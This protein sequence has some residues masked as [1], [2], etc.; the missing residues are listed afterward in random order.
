MLAFVTT[1]FRLLLNLTVMFLLVMFVVGM[2]RQLVAPRVSKSLAAA[3]GKSKGVGGYLLAL[4]GGMVTPFC[5]CSAVPAVVG[6]LGGGVAMGVVITFL[7]AAPVVHEGTFLLMWASMGPK[8]ALAFLITAAAL[9]MVLGVIFS[10]F[11]LDHLVN[12]VMIEP[13]RETALTNA[14]SLKTKVKVSLLQAWDLF[15]RVWPYLLV[16]V[17]IGAVMENFVPVETVQRVVMAVGP[18]GVIIVTLLCAPLYAR[19]EVLVPIGIVLLHRG[20]PIGTVVAFI[21][22]FSVLSVPEFLLLSKYFKPKLLAAYGA[23][24]TLAIIL[25]GYGFNLAYTGRL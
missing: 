23:A 22:S 19:I 25:M 16:G 1:F 12:R 13:R 6:L 17:A 21:M 15:K 4:G 10:L 5:S 9:A 8:G 18:L 3:L 11:K 7:I 2:L 14:P 24:V 20:V